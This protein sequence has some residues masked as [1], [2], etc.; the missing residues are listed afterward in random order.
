MYNCNYINNIYKLYLKLYI[1]Y[2]I[3][4]FLLS[5]LYEF[6]IDEYQIFLIY[7]IFILWY[8]NIIGLDKILIFGLLIY[9]MYE[10]GIIYKLQQKINDKYID[11]VKSVHENTGVILA[12]FSSTSVLKDQ[13]SAQ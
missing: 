2:F 10:N 13:N 3:S 7:G 1:F 9:L 5:I 4:V 12:E 6:K 11:Y 8:F